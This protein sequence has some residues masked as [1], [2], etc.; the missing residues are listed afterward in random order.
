MSVQAKR[1]LRRGQTEPIELIRPA[2]P[3]S[4]ADSRLPVW[5]NGKALRKSVKYCDEFEAH[6]TGIYKGKSPRPG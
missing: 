6:F 5:I 1:P 4:S 3:V 2:G